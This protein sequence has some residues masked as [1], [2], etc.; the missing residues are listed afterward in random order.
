[1]SFAVIVPT[2]NAGEAWPTWIDAIKSQSRNPDNI[3]IIDSGSED[4]TVKLSNA[5]GFNVQVLQPGTFNHGGTRK[6]A[7][8]QNRNYE[9]LVFLTQDAILADSNALHNILLPFE[10]E[11]V[12]A[13]CGRQLPRRSAGAIETHARLFNYPVA[14]FVR[15]YA[16]KEAYGIKAAFLSNSFA[17]Y[18]VSAL[19]ELGS[20]P[21][22]VIFGED[23]YVAAKLLLAGGKIAYAA[24]ACVYH[25]H[26]YTLKQEFSRYF[27]MGVFHASEPWISEQFGVAEK[28]GMR[29]VVSELRYMLEYAIWRI[30]EALL[31]TLLRYVGFKCGLNEHWFPGWF[32]QKMSMNPAY[33][34]KK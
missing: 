13:V 29:F 20:F 34:C 8:L 27:D 15:I 16:D 10:D 33:F 30:P 28:E 22:N 11:L 4:D 6:Q 14:S 1:M 24:D 7:V 9:F 18:R 23:M 2:L 19:V 26:H 17:A 25:S 3:L 31:R 32:K 12:M 5:A 21:E